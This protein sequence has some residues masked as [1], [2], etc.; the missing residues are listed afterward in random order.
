MLDEP[1]FYGTDLPLN[2]TPIMLTRPDCEGSATPTL[3]RAA[4]PPQERHRVRSFGLTP[5]GPNQRLPCSRMPFAHARSSVSRTAGP[6]RPARPQSSPT[7]V[8]HRP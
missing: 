1:T 8:L 4:D 2:R 7:P 3:V 5:D 6:G